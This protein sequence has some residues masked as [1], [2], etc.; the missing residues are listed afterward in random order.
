MVL[1]V[2][3]LAEPAACLPSGTPDCKAS[4]ERRGAK[5]PCF[6]L[7]CRDNSRMQRTASYTGPANKSAIGLQE[8]TTGEATRYGM[9]WS[10]RMPD[11][12]TRRPLVN[13]VAE[14]KVKHFAKDG[15][16]WRL[17]ALFIDKLP[18]IFRNAAYVAAASWG[19]HKLWP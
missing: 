8:E 5:S 12:Q 1:S 7:P 13:F 4:A 10:I 15:P 18:A 3:R 6:Y 11:S 2:L 14:D 9:L 19:I 16:A 17:G